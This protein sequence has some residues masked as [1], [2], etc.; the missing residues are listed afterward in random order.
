M[1]NENPEY[2]TVP[3][4]CLTWDTF[5]GFRVETEP[6]KAQSGLRRNSRGEP[7]FGAFVRQEDLPALLTR[8]AQLGMA[9]DVEMRPIPPE[10]RKYYARTRKN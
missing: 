9:V 7:V 3:Y 10:G 1:T 8:C 5:H 2:K 4:E 6:P